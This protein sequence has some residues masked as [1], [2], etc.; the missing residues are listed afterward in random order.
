MDQPYD[1]HQPAGVPDAH[2][3]PPINPPGMMP[4]P[5]PGPPPYYPPPPPPSRTGRLFGW[6]VTSIMLSLLVFSVG[7]N[8]YLF[9][10]LNTL[11]SGPHEQ[12]Y[13]EAKGPK[14]I[15]IL[16]VEGIIG[17]GTYEFVRQSLEMLRKNK[18]VA[19]ILRVDSPGGSPGPCD[20]IYHE[21][22]RFREETSIPVLASFGSVAASGGYYISAGCDWILVEPSCITGS[23]GVLSQAFTFERLMDKIGVT[24]EVLAASESPEKDIANNTFRQWDERDRLVQRKV[25][26]MMH[27]RFVDVVFEGRQGLFKTRD[28]ALVVCNG[29][30]Y[31]AEEAV[32]NQLVDATGFIGEAIDE[33]K[34]LA[35]LDAQSDPL[36]TIIHRPI[37]LGLM[38][39]L[40]S[41]SS[42]RLPVT[43]K[44]VRNII[45]EMSTPHVEYLLR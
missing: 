26:D 8:F 42:S 28:D 29:R 45:L 19:I 32:A 2:S 5:P 40:G 36:I 13:R 31:N 39:L 30:I 12:T 24:P 15:V 17:E 44:D 35:G 7:G 34:A 9:V 21:I 16:P 43:A 27:K 20:R 14:R 11:T 41:S 23:I 10:M 22:R 38:G 1:P 37:S 18:P 25:V 3:R 4:P 6:S 33:A